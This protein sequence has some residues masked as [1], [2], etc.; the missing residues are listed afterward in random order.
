[1]RYLPVENSILQ[2]YEG[3]A[4]EIMAANGVIVPYRDLE[5]GGARQ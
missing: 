1:M 2:V 5:P 3:A 4:Y